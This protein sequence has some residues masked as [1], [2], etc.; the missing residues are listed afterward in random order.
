MTGGLRESKVF[1][2]NDIKTTNEI[3]VSLGCGVD[4]LTGEEK[5][6]SVGV[7]EQKIREKQDEIW[8]KWNEECKRCREKS[9]GAVAIKRVRELEV[10]NKKLKDKVDKVKHDAS[11]LEERVKELEGRV[12]EALETLNEFPFIVNPA[13]GVKRLRGVL[14]A[15]E[16]PE[17][18][19]DCDN[20]SCSFNNDYVC[21]K[22]DFSCEKRF[23]IGQESRRVK[24]KG[25]GVKRQENKQK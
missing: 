8:K 22:Q 7:A 6:V 20:D 3:Y 10:E 21:S 1:G 11:Y 2:E 17:G 5:W 24:K 23:L 15:P 19:Y 18:K 9:Q 25:V 16:T 12:R 4:G 14:S 13:E